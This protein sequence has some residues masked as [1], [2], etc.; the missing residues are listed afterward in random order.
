MCHQCKYQKQN[1]FTFS[2]WHKCFSLVIHGHNRSVDVYSCDSSDWHKSARIIDAD[3]GHG[4]LYTRKWDILMLNQ[5][6][7][8]K[9]LPNHLVWLMQCRMNGWLL[10]EISKF[11]ADSPTLTIHV[12][13]LNKPLDVT[14]PLILFIVQWTT[15]Y[16]DT[17]K[18]SIKSS[19]A[20]N[21]IILKVERCSH[22]T[23]MKMSNAQG[24]PDTNLSLG[25]FN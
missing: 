14:N 7:Y 22:S 8:L 23:L 21:T 12:I 24:P 11:L 20:C 5:A 4:N 9:A 2:S 13:Q 10:H 1:K 6:I 16:F 25:I 15:S 18:L 3:V 19:L 17:I